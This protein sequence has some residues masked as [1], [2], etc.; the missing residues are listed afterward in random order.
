MSVTSSRDFFFNSET[1]AFSYMNHLKNL[2][3]LLEKP[4]TCK[5][6]KKKTMPM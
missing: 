1:K 5:C 3:F 2:N 6:K 4:F